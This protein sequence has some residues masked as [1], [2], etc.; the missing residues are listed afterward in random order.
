MVSGKQVD[1]SAARELKQCHQP[2]LP[3]RIAVK[4][5]LRHLDRLMPGEQ[6]NVAQAAAGLVRFSRRRSK[7]RLDTR[8]GPPA[9]GAEPRQ[10]KR[11]TPSSP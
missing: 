7:R 9:A 10:L 6:L 2:A 3:A 11:V 1:P 8:E 4:I 5:A